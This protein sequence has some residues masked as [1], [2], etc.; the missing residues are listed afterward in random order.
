LIDWYIHTAIT[1]NTKDT[2]AIKL[3]SIGLGYDTYKKF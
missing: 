1:K 3:F 2:Y